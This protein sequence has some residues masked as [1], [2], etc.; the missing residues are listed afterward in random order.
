MRD[1]TFTTSPITAYSF[2]SA[3]PMLPVT[4]SP[5]CNVAAPQYV[6]I[7]VN[8]QRMRERVEADSNGAFEVKIPLNTIP[9]SGVIEAVQQTSAGRIF[10][11][12]KS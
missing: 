5:A 3:D 9:G 4:A 12:G 10:V 1:A 11:N 6:T 7:Y 8:G 2:R